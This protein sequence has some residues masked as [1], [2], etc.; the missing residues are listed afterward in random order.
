MRTLFLSLLILSVTC[1]KRTAEQEHH[2]EPLIHEY[3][4]LGVWLVF[5]L[6]VGVFF[7]A[8]MNIKEIVQPLMQRGLSGIKIAFGI[9][10]I[11][12]FASYVTSYL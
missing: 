1:A 3:L 10:G 11:F 7:E 12:T 4:K 5:G 8:K 9:Y 6:I 2:E